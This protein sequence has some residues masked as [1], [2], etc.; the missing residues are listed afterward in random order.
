VGL[1]FARWAVLF[2]ILT[3]SGCLFPPRPSPKGLVFDVLVNLNATAPG[4]SLMVI[5]TNMAESA[6]NVTEFSWVLGSTPAFSVLAPDG[7]VYDCISLSNLSMLAKQVLL[8]AGE[9][10]SRTYDLFGEWTAWRRRS[11]GARFSTIDVFSGPGE[12]NVTATYRPFEMD[13]DPSRRSAMLVSS[14]IFAIPADF[15]A[16][17]EVN[18]SI[19]DLRLSTWTI[20]TQPAVPTNRSTNMH[21]FRIFGKAVNH[22]DPG[23]ATIV[24]YLETDRGRL[25]KEQTLYFG[26]GSSKTI[27]QDFE[28]PD[29]KIPDVLQYGIAAIGQE[30]PPD[31]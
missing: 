24:T 21:V 1:S 26:V 12:Y 8:E 23:W 30:P 13:R 7:T 17:Y 5:C 6:E 14:R 16:F 25:Q 9:S 3:I 2:L 28:I 29:G 15:W 19:T 31:S 22:G 18:V 20:L 10:I 11:D 4:L 27:L